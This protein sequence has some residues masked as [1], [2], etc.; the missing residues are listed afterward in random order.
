MTQSKLETVKMVRPNDDPILYIARRCEFTRIIVSLTLNQKLWLTSLGWR[1]EEKSIALNCDNTAQGLAIRIPKKHALQIMPEDIIHISCQE[2]GFQAQMPWGGTHPVT[3]PHNTE[4]MASNALSSSIVT[5]HENIKSKKPKMLIFGGIATIAIL[6]IIGTSVIGKN[7][8]P[9]TAIQKQAQITKV[10]TNSAS[11]DE[12]EANNIDAK[13]RA[14][15]KREAAAAIAAE[16]EKKK[17]AADIL[18]AKNIEDKKAL[19]DKK[20]IAKPTQEAKINVPKK[21]RAKKET[22]TLIKKDDIKKAKP[23]TPQS[24]DIKKTTSVVKTADPIG[25]NL[26]IQDTLKTPLSSK[27]AKLTVLEITKMQNDLAYMGYHSGP[28]D[29]L[30]SKNTLSS[31]DFFKSIF[32]IP[33]NSPIDQILLAEIEKQRNSY[34]KPTKEP[35]VTPRVD[36]PPINEQQTAAPIRIA[37]PIKAPTAP[38]IIDPNTPAETTKTERTNTPSQA[39]EINT[40]KDIIT[41]DSTPK[42]APVL[43]NTGD[44]TPPKLIKKAALKYPKRPSERLAFIEDIVK[45]VISFSVNID[46]EPVNIQVIN[47]TH[48]GPFKT[49]FNKAALKVAR[50]QE[51]EPALSAN[52][53]PIAV[54]DNQ[55]TITFKK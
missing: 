50:S 27:P 5:E 55:V 33:K 39:A 4:S 1:A 54:E 10:T 51:F 48:K 42:P 28:S 34:V 2:L 37:L 8:E 49:D 9:N 35:L 44:I 19:E 12:V 23:N 6:A 20:D 11:K 26:N 21:A 53:T 3:L 47:N 17:N 32:E 16:I 7:S 29:G 25:E 45:V 22:P 18:A 52:G 40:P 36:E 30:L 43:S 38:I 13:T 14:D 24:Q 46:G 15:L 41:S 31:V